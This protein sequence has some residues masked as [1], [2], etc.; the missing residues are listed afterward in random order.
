RPRG[1]EAAADG[2]RGRGAEAAGDFARGE[3]GMTV[4]ILLA[5]L[6]LSGTAEAP[7]IVKGDEDSFVSRSYSLFVDCVA[8]SATPKIE[9]SH[10]SAT[11]I[12]DAAF[13]SCHDE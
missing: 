3:C 7:A 12:T 9:K 11:A 13:A 5:G 2:V 8:H 10:A 4:G 6:F 1:A